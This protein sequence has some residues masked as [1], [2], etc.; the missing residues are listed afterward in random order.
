MEKVALKSI[1]KFKTFWLLRNVKF[2][3]EN[4]RDNHV[5]AFRVTKESTIKFS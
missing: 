5:D 4:K 1:F 3:R 2:I